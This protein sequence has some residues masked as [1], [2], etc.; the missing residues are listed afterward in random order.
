M[1]FVLWGGS[2]GRQGPGCLPPPWHR[3]LD[4]GPPDQVGQGGD[5]R[6][7]RGRLDRHRLPRRRG[8]PG[9][10][11]NPY[12]Q[13]RWSADRA[14]HP[15]GRRPGHPVAGMAPPRVHHRPDR[16]GCLVGR[17]PSPP[18][19]GRARHPRPQ[20]GT[21]Q[22]HCPS[23]VFGANAAWAL[24]AT[25]AHNL[26]RWV[27]ALGLGAQGLVVAKTIRRRLITLPGRLTHTARRR[28]LHL[29]SGWPWAKG[30][31]TALARLRALP[32]RTD[33][34]HAR[35]VPPIPLPSGSAKRARTTV[36]PALKRSSG[37]LSPHDSNQ[38][39]SGCLTTRQPPRRPYP[40]LRDR[41]PRTVP[42]WIQA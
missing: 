38:S 3:V 24:V 15:P 12:W 11:D 17:R 22:C 16:H 10:R 34:Q 4:H 29:P 30:F 32:L 9:G 23:G 27:A 20:A 42:R 6:H 13:G 7:R 21:G 31:L 37:N 14:P 41:H 25:L 39:H 33:P 8:R 26:L 40:S 1:R 5:R 28:H 18:R 35:A 36:R 2:L 19:R